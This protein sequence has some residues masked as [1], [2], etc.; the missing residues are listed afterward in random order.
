MDSFFFLTDL[1][2]LLSAKVEYTPRDIVVTPDRFN[3]GCSEIIKIFLAFV[4]ELEIS[5]KVS[6]KNFEIW[7]IHS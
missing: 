7:L 1:F 4:Q 2:N 6:Y 3:S 5:Y